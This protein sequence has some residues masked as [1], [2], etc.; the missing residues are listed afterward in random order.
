MPYV[1]AGSLFSRLQSIAATWTGGTVT[2][3]FLSIAAIGTATDAF[4]LRSICT[5]VDSINPRH[6]HVLHK[7]GAAVSARAALNHNARSAAR[8]SAQHRRA[9]QA[10]AAA[11]IPR[12]ADPWAAA[13]LADHATRIRAAAAPPPAAPTTAGSHFS[14]VKEFA[15]ASASAIAAAVRAAARRLGAS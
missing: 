13:L 11:A 6:A 10:A 4:F 7:V 12:D 14:S 8:S 15:A 9:H 5:A 2:Y 3:Y 1:K